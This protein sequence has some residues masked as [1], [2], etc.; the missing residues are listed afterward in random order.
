MEC[1]WLATEGTSNARKEIH[2][3]MTNKFGMVVDMDEMQE[4]ILKK[5][6]RNSELQRKLEEVTRAQEEKIHGLQV[7]D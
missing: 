5:F 6:Q 2:E 4:T 7:K 1:N 3:A